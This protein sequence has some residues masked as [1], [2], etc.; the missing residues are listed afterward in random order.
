MA[1]RRLTTSGG[2]LGIE[3]IR[4][5]GVPRERLKDVVVQ[6]TGNKGEFAT[7]ILGNPLYMDV[8]KTSEEVVAA[9]VALKKREPSLEH[10]VLEL[11][12]HAVLS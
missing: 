10:V 7:A 9:A 5:A 12:Q 3:H 6:G 1:S 11:H 8:I 2:K 4:A